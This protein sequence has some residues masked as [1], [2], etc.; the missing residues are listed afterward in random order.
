MGTTSSLGQPSLPSFGAE[1]ASFPQDTHGQ[2]ETTSTLQPDPSSGMLAAGSVLQPGANG[3]SHSLGTESFL[4][5]PQHSL[6]Q[7]E[8]QAQSHAHSVSNPSFNHATA[9]SKAPHSGGQDILSDTLYT[10][11]V[12]G[13]ES[14]NLPPIRQK[15]SN[16]KVDFQWGS[17]TAFASQRGFVPERHESLE[18]IMRPHIQSLKNALTVLGPDSANNTAPSSPVVR[19]KSISEIKEEEQDDSRPFKRRKSKFQDEGD[20]QDDSLNGAGAGPNSTKRRKPS[21]RTSSG[22]PTRSPTD[23][24]ANTNGNSKRRKSSGAEKKSGRENLTEEQKRENHIRSEQKRRTLIR[25]G[26]EDLNELV[27]GLKGGGFSKSTVLIMTAEWLEELL[28]GNEVLRSR[29]HEMEG[30]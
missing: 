8:N 28:R 3:H 2:M 20:D 16:L 14:A 11:M 26:F 9:G 30:R 18:N 7:P 21:N 25:E 29:I 10:E 1:N 17:D 6:S 15:I 19:R 4:S 24:S 22:S 27:P 12:F 5:A 23:L 13:R